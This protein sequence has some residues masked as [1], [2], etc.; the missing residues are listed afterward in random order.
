MI[1]TGNTKS[2]QCICVFKQSTPG[3]NKFLVITIYIDLMACYFQ[4]TD[5]QLMLVSV[6]DRIIFV[7]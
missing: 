4:C 3:F 7:P 2:I 6:C 1:N 5:M